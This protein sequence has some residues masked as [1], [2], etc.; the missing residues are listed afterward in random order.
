MALDPLP[1][2]SSADAAAAPIGDDPVVRFRTWFGASRALDVK[3]NP[4]VLFHGTSGLA[5]DF[6]PGGAARPFETFDKKFLGQ[7]TRT[8]DAKVGFWFTSSIDRARSAGDDAVMV[9]SEKEEEWGGHN[10]YAPYIFAVHLR[11]ERPMTIDTLRGRSPASVAR[12]A[13]KAKEAGH[14]GLVFLA[15]EDGGSDYLVF[16]PEQIHVLPS[17][18]EPVQLQ[19]SPLRDVTLLPTFKRWFGSSQVL[20][21]GKPKVMYHAT[22]VWEGDG[23][24]FGDVTSFDRLF[25]RKAFNRQC[26]DQVGSWFSDNPT[27]ETGAAMYTAGSGVMYPVYLS[28]SKPF[29]TSFQDLMTKAQ[30]VSRQP[31][32]EK[33]NGASVEALR[34]W[35]KRNGYDGIQIVHDEDR[36]HES[37]EFR[38]QD[39]WVALEP[40]QIK[41][42]IGN[43]GSFDPNS[44]DIRFS[45]ERLQQEEHQAAATAVAG[46]PQR[47][48]EFDT[49]F[50]GSL[51]VEPNGE[52]RVLYHGTSGDYFDEFNVFGLA[53]HFGT[54]EAAESILQLHSGVPR[55]DMPRTMNYWQGARV[56]PVHLAVRNPVRVPDPTNWDAD[57]LLY[58]LR[59]EGVITQEE[60]DKLYDQWER[61]FETDHESGR[62][63]IREALVRK[64]YDAIVYTNKHEDKGSDSY[65]VFSAQQVRSAIASP[66]PSADVR[67]RDA[68]ALAATNASGQPIARSVE[69]LERFWRW[70]GDTK[71]ADEHGRPMV[72]YHGSAL[73]S[74][75]EAGEFNAQ[76][77]SDMI[78]AYFSADPDVAA[79]YAEMDAEVEGD[80]PYIIPVY[81]SLRNPVV[82]SDGLSHQV[83]T[84][85]E[86]DAWI[87][88][89]YDG[90]VG[91][92]NGKPI[93]FVAFH[94]T[95]VKS[96]VGNSGYFDP[97]DGRIRHR[98]SEQELPLLNDK[99]RPIASDP[100]ALA[101]FWEWAGDTKAVDAQGRPRVLY[102]GT[103]GSI[104]AFDPAL[105]GSRHVDMEVGPAYYFTDDVKTASWYAKDSGKQAKG[106]ANV[107]PVYLSMKN[108][109]IVDFQEE[110]IEYL[111]EELV[112]AK[113]NGHDGLICRN[114]NDGGVSDHYIVFDP[115]QVKSAIGNE[116]TFDPSSSDLVL[117]DDD[118]TATVRPPPASLIESPQFKHWFGQSKAVTLGGEPLVLYH[119]THAEGIE[120]FEATPRDL[121]WGD[122]DI[123]LTPFYFTDSTEV[124][125]SYGEHTV[126]AF[127]SLQN[128]KVLNARGRKWEDF[129]LFGKTVDAFVAGHDGLIVKNVMDDAYGE[130]DGEIESTVYVVFSPNQ[131]KS[132]DN[133]GSF[134]P[135]SPL[136]RYRQGDEPTRAGVRNSMGKPIGDD[137]GVSR[138][139]S[140]AGDTKVVDGEGKPTVVFHGSRSDITAFKPGSWFAED[141]K[142][143]ERFF[144][145]SRGQ[146]RGGSRRLY[147]AYL[148]IRKPLDVRSCG[149]GEHVTSER[150]AHLLGMSIEELRSRVWDFRKAD[151]MR[152]R[153][154]VRLR[155]DAPSRT[156]INVTDLGTL[157]FS[158]YGDEHDEAIPTRP[159]RLWE[160]LRSTR[161]FLEHLGYDGIRAHEWLPAT[162][163]KARL[164]KEVG[165]DTW[166]V[167]R[168]EQ[169]KSAVGNDGIFDPARADIRHRD[170]AP[171]DDFA[172]WAE[173][174]ELNGPD[175]QPLVFYHGSDEEPAA[176]RNGEEYGGGIYVTNNPSYAQVFGRTLVPLY[177]RASR[178]VR[179]AAIPGQLQGEQ[180]KAWAVAHGYDGIR[181][182]KG[183][184][185]GV[186]T[187]QV[188]VFRPDQVRPALRVRSNDAFARWFS[189]S[190]IVDEEGAP[191]IVYHGT[192]SDFAE[193]D[194]L[195]V[196]SA[197]DQGWY[198]NGFY[199]TP[200]AEVASQA[201]ASGE[202]GN[203]MPVYLSIQNPFDW[204]SEHE[205]GL[206]QNH[207]ATSLAMRAEL[208]Q[209]G[210]DGVVVYD[211]WLQ[212]PEGT[213]LTDAQW[214][215]IA[216]DPAAAMGRATVS[217]WLTR[218][219]WAYEDI[220][221][222]YGRDFAMS[223][224][225]ARREVKEIVA[226]RPTQIKSALGNAGTFDA[227][228]ADI[229]LKDAEGDDKAI[230]TWFSGSRVRDERGG[231]LVVYHGTKEQFDQFDVSK[232]SDCME[233]GGFF[234]T[235]DLCRAMPYGPRILSANLSI[236]NP[237]E[238]DPISWMEGAYDDGERR[239]RI[240]IPAL[241]AQGYDGIRI[242]GDPTSAGEPTWE[243]GNDVWIAFDPAQVRILGDVPG[244]DPY[245]AAVRQRGAEALGQW[246]GASKLVDA[247]GAP[248][249]VYHGTKADFTQFDPEMEG[250]GQNYGAQVPGHWFATDP[251]IAARFGHNILQ[252]HLRMER[253]FRIDAA[254]YMQR[255]M[256]EEEDPVAFRRELEEAGHDGIIIAPD[257]EYLDGRGPS[258]TEEWGQTNFVV[259]HPSQVWHVSTAQRAPRA[260]EIELPAAVTA[261]RDANA[262][263]VEP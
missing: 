191:K 76:R 194:H 181:S 34:A 45:L 171:D 104:E 249:T 258:G 29:I 235:P 88:Q 192:H 177:V 158:S 211:D 85:E 53:T 7:V 153:E 140:W 8:S 19:E 100:T 122:R 132:R 10:V 41:S 203:L 174:S 254:E 27:K 20:R 86:R 199:F 80:A 95:Q 232:V 26:L 21:D 51:L 43:D 87:A 141:P 113:E 138:F 103:A 260:G 219:E 4:E 139:W 30:R 154:Q 156:V 90:V 36:E 9:E 82:L 69:E 106:G 255:F 14:D 28:I 72:V 159:S 137:V 157:S 16:E 6:A 147:P 236:K 48:S 2:V 136:I 37:I 101:R 119:G 239:V 11:I 31:L 58:L 244:F 108:P 99:G 77:S 32:A 190:K 84:P 206:F 160:V 110:G 61:E 182:S 40:A 250:R 238:I 242:D 83:I 98:E 256:Y 201:Y 222:S 17:R 92:W 54:R 68:P 200:S 166:M 96:A 188:V 197:S 210:F 107:V 3:G 229:R 208:E 173:G 216:G 231:P 93:E 13:K 116:G 62:D 237:F 226:F 259:F 189:R 18:N 23:F 207:G 124:A 117:R 52:P 218:K 186:N 15:G 204:R 55:S 243:F 102:H 24:T 60:H 175:G 44:P 22:G 33:P 81:L 112:R 73:P 205:R 74:L 176:S 209:R 252:V 172:R 168:S 144:E 39:V 261:H 184:F 247:A 35:L 224:P 118:A 25:T 91:V 65:I 221:R 57:F 230:D 248:I 215:M 246:L 149:I 94:P 135:N 70:I 46:E 185:G 78:G 169:V 164:Y 105:V 50:N 42:A 161:S 142:L 120:R 162:S 38:D 152:E 212:L 179:A 148:A 134:D 240:N 217:N 64:G 97:S 170:T 223:L 133:V 263:G 67:L 125:Q 75:I 198:G 151:V 129:G 89:G 178:I 146:H 126:E 257:E 183:N 111:E 234:F 245:S 180:A 165:S 1:D 123:V 130:G 114:Y 59:A 115:A 155:G 12:L 47:R 109:L 131:I 220:S 225:K 241:K 56:H 128:P 193:F 127:L 66:A 253:P 163:P 195:R 228:N 121:R 167:F 79:S 71:V 213:Q 150:F 251:A 187:E 202:G 145:G 49:W 233:E 196:G 227:G 63:C 262:E 143:A 214:E 5:D